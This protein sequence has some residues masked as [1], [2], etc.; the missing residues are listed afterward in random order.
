MTTIQREPTP[1]ALAVAAGQWFIRLAQA[2]I[3]ERGVFHV[4]LSGGS[5]PKRIHHWLTENARHLDWSR[6]HVWMGDERNVDDH[7]PDSNARMIRQTLLEPL[8][9]S[10]AN[11]RPMRTH[12]DPDDSSQRYQAAL[13]H[14]FSGAL[15]RFDLAYLGL[16]ADMHTASLFPHTPAIDETERWVVANPVAQL[17]Q[18]RLT[19]TFPVLNNARTVIVVVAGAE[20]RQALHDVLYRTAPLTQ[21]PAQRLAPTDGQLVWLMDEAAATL[22]TGDPA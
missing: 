21:S 1:E 9:L 8:G 2:A 22:I 15:P 3:T 16:G 6:I 13:H 20:K 19:L 4:A 17:N 11:F 14:T 7:H 5:T 10:E 12:P 18:T